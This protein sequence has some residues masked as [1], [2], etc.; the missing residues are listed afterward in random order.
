MTCAL[1]SQ[2]SCDRKK[3][4]AFRS[5]LSG[6]CCLHGGKENC[7]W[8]SG[9]RSVAEEKH[10]EDLIVKARIILAYLFLSPSCV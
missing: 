8:G 4:Y 7:I 9:S 1:S 6:L 3:K 10:L 2:V 5:N